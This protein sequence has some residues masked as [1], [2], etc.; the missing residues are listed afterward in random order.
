LRSAELGF[1]GVLVVT[2]TQT[3]RL[4]GA[5]FSYDLFFRLLTTLSK[6]G[7]LDFTVTFL[8]GFRTN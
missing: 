2:F 4:N 7:D 1:L 5:D 6:A 8:R 3:P